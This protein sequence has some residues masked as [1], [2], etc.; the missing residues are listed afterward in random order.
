MSYY[1]K[2]IKECTERDR[3]KMCIDVLILFQYVSE[4]AIIFLKEF[5]GVVK[6]LHLFDSVSSKS[7][8]CQSKLCL[9]MQ[10]L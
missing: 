3:N 9:C 6:A 10:K 1:K 7:V 2:L 4:A 5:F 8:V